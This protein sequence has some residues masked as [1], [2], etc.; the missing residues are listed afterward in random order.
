MKKLIP[1]LLLVGVST[2]VLA[3]WTGIGKS[4]DGDTTIYIDFTTIRKHGDLVKMWHLYDFQTTKTASGIR[5]FSSKGQEEYD[6]KEEQSRALAF[7][8]F[9]DKMGDG[10]ANYSGVVDSNWN[11][12]S[13]GS[14]DEKLFKIACGIK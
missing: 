8:M 9:F 13:P 3:K 12:V 1:M 2:N 6:C 10:V 14:I 4:P 11:P 7:S 5:Y